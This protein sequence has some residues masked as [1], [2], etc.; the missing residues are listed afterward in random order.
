M[1]S[2]T[3]KM[4]VIFFLLL[5][6]TQDMAE[7]DKIVIA[8][9]TSIYTAP[10]YVAKAKGFWI[11]L[12]LDVD[13]KLVRGVRPILTLLKNR[14]A[15]LSIVSGSSVARGDLSDSEYVILATIMSSTRDMQIISSKER[16]VSSVSDLKGKKIGL[17]KNLVSR[18]FLKKTLEK[19]GMSFNDVLLVSVEP[20]EMILGL[21]EGRIDAYV[22][23]GP[24]FFM[25]KRMLGKNAV[26][27]VED[28]IYT[29]TF[30]LVAGKWFVKKFPEETK[31]IIEGLKKAVLYMETESVASIQI[32]ADATKIESD[33]VTSV[34][35][36]YRFKV[37][38]NE[39]LL[40]SLDLEAGWIERSSG[41]R[42]KSERP[43]FNRMIYPE[44]LKAV[45]PDSVTIMRR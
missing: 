18:M 7:A 17:S 34:W 21:N 11:D 40:K 16:G 27:M 23:W 2:L 20:Q 10:V 37:E 15:D 44:P 4:V 35:P 9:S 31:K 39:S 24:H 25:V 14:E 45:A 42:A 32:V 36:D 29:L 26:R 1:N 5:V 30:N 28:D 41:G 13:L 33:L 38:L 22:I 6:A 3:N 12:G 43:D 8:D 19:Y